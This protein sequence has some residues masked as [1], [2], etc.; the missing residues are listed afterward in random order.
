[1]GLLDS[2]VGALQQAQGS[3]GAQPDLMRVVVGMLANDGAGGGLPGL[4][5]RFQQGGLGDVVQS[6]IGSGQNLPV[7]PD[8]L[9]AVL[10][11]DTLASLARQFGLAPAD[12]ATQLSQLLPGVVDTLTPQG[13]LPSGG[14]GNAGDLLSAFLRR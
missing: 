9:R 5:A 4:V 2:V 11:G 12:V 7:S 3:G 14:L 10:G 8:Q 1:M 6:W 13:H